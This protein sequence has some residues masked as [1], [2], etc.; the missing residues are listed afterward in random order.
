MYLFYKIVDKLVAVP[1]KTD[2]SDVLYNPRF[3]AVIIASLTKL[4]RATLY[5]SLIFQ[6]CN[7]PST[8]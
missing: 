4:G 7:L 5:E 1:A 6:G 3:L 2:S 8:L